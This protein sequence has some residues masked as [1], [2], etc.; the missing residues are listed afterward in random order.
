[1]DG[2]SGGSG[3]RDVGEAPAAE[4]RCI[5]RGLPGRVRVSEGWDELAVKL[6]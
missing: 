5:G 1:M 4:L 2:L 6:P 3:I